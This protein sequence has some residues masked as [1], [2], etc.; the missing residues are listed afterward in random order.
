MKIRI[1]IAE[2]NQL[3]L[4]SLMDKLEPYKDI[5]IKHTAQNGVVLLNKLEEDPQIEL[6]LMDLQMPQMNGIIATGEIIKHWPQ[7]KILV[8]TMFDDD[9]SIFDAI[10]AGASG[11]LLKEGS[12]EELYKGIKDTLEGG[13][14]MSPG[15]ALK[16]L[17]MI[18]KP[19]APSTPQQDFGL[20][21]RE[22]EILNQLKSGLTYE[23]TASNLNISYFT[24]RK[25]I[26]N[27]YRKMQVSN[28]LEA[29]HKASD[30]NLIQ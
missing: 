30:N 25:H 14:A 8:V 20:T 13:S 29:V 19:L 10:M 3:V 23:K 15:I 27:I 18:R 12:G 16:V 6:V 28:K 24:V 17:K 1:A 22:I 11:Y 21:P 7:I 4:K 9:E 26:E 2:D 5:L